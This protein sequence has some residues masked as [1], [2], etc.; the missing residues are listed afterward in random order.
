MK[1]IVQHGQQDYT[2]LVFIQDSASTTGAGKTG[3]DNTKVDFAYVRVETD[4]DVTVTACAP[5][6]LSA[7][8]DAHTDWG[9]KEVSSTEAP[10]WYRLDCADGVFAA[11]AWSAGVHIRDAGSN[12]VAPCTLEFQL[13]PWNPNDSVRLGLT[14]LPNAAA[15]AAGG[16]P[17]SDAGG[18]DLDTILDVAIS[19][20]AVAGDEMTL[21]AAYDAAKT[22][23]QAG[24][25]M[26]LTV[27]YD[28][29]K[30]AAQAGDA[31]DLDSNALVSAADAILDEAVEGTLTLRQIQRLLLATLAGKV[32]G[33]GTTSIK[34]RDQA[35]NTDRIT[36]TVD[37]NGNRS[38]TTVDVS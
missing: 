8:T 15:D 38:A 13:V 23:A 2:V 22:A 27:A 20:R 11:G 21:T 3:L 24:D 14:A 30:T 26:T 1:Q 25:E 7:L 33:G 32:S 10:G 5:A 9:F 34:Y 37:A 31:M 18:L 35:D 6:S 17:I 16:L 4:N 29:A 12:G 19:T 28:A 36:L